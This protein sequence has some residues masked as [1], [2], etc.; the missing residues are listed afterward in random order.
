[1]WLAL[2]RWAVRE[3]AAYNVAFLCTSGHEYENLGSEHVLRD[4]APPPDKVALWLHLGANVATCDWHE[5]G[6]GAF[7]PLPSADPQRFLVTSPMLVAAARRAFAGLPGLEMAYPSDQGSAGELTNIIAA[8]YS[9]VAGIFGAHRFHHARTDDARCVSPALT[10]RVIESC[11]A[12][13][14]EL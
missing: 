14:S 11:K 7:L 3:L 10:G 8:G 2:A 13:I 4:A 1:V 9:R 12:M 6:A 5:L